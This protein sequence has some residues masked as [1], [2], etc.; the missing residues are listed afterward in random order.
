MKDF[1]PGKLECS[2]NLKKKPKGKVERNT[3]LSVLTARCA[4][5]SLDADPPVNTCVQRE[6]H[7]AQGGR[8]GTICENH[9][10]NFTIRQVGGHIRWLFSEYSNQDLLHHTLAGIVTPSQWH[11]WQSSSE[12]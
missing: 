10:L 12:F 3:L 6:P 5:L 7:Q 11:N 9:R 2:T 1:E 4:I 8:S